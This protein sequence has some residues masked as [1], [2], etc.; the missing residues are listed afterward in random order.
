MAK[1]YVPQTKRLASLLV[2]SRSRYGKRNRTSAQR[3]RLR[4]FRQL[5]SDLPR[6]VQGDLALDHTE[7]SSRSIR[8]KR[9]N[10][11]SPA[12]KRKCNRRGRAL[13][14][15]T[16]DFMLRISCSFNDR[17]KWMISLPSV[18]GLPWGSK[19]LYPSF[20]YPLMTRPTRPLQLVPVIFWILRCNLVVVVVAMRMKQEVL[21][22]R[23]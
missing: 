3:C 4:V 21:L 18:P 12:R 14:A 8:S 16:F 2:D 7:S 20:T 6:Y 5:E 11:I 9:R 10:D 15:S 22:L 13:T 17:I 1:L 19:R 23:L